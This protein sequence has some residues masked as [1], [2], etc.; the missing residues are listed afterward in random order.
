ML[1]RTAE[2]CTAEIAEGVK[3]AAGFRL[4]PGACSVE[5]GVELAR[6]AKG[7]TVVRLKGAPSLH[8]GTSP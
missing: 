2:E 8:P 3:T 1:A 6:G 7:V 4:Q 5:S